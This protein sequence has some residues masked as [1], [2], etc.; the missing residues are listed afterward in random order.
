MTFHQDEACEDLLL[1]RW[2]PIW[3]RHLVVGVVT[4]AIFAAPLAVLWFAGQGSELWPLTKP[5]GPVKLVSLGLASCLVV[6]VLFTAIQVGLSFIPWLLGLLERWKGGHLLGDRPRSLMKRIVSLRTPLA[7]FGATLIASIG[8]LV[9]VG[10][11]PMELEAMPLEWPWEYI[12]SRTMMAACIVALSLLVK[13]IIVQELSWNYHQQFYAERIEANQFVLKHVRRLKQAFPLADGSAASVT[14]TPDHSSGSQWDS[15]RIQRHAQVIFNALR[16]GQSETLVSGDLER[17]LEPADASRLFEL[18]DRDANGDLT[19]EEF[20]ESVHQAYIDR[21]NLTDAMIQNTEVIQLLD[22]FA[23]FVAIMFA[24]LIMLSLYSASFTSIVA[25]FGVIGIVGEFLSE[26]TTNSF[27]AVVFIFG[28]HPFDVGDIIWMDGKKYLV[29]SIQLNTTSLGG[30]GHRTEYHPNV[31]LNDKVIAN[32]RRSDPQ[33]EP[34]TIYFSMR[35]TNEQLVDLE[36]KM[37]EFLQENSRDF[38][39]NL[40]IKLAAFENSDTMRIEF[41]IPH[42]S[43]FQNADVRAERSR[44]FRAAMEGYIRDIGIKLGPYPWAYK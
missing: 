13:S 18:F 23:T 26:M 42:R 31:N 7:W 43:N 14:P 34:V 2:I 35:T 36:E 9:L 28:T 39:P 20:V 33:S 22:R 15:E 6:T 21:D 44:R 11:L 5:F 1:K 16:H 17:V 12:I 32:L 24:G 10:E 8:I 27:I 41:N 4:F 38:R 3:V 19:V 37:R 29:K 40:F 25:S 30:Q